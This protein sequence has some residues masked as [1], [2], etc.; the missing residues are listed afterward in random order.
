MLNWYV[1]SSKKKKLNYNRMSII[2]N[3]NDCPEGQQEE[4]VLIH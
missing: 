2:I 1:I 4:S 3:T